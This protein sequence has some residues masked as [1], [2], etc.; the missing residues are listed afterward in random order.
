M[1][2]AKRILKLIEY[3][4]IIDEN[5]D[6]YNKQIIGAIAFENVSFYYNKSPVLKNLSFSIEPGE[7]VAIVGQTGSGKTTLTKLISRIN[8]VDN[9]K[10]LID[11][12]N[13]KVSVKS[14]TPRNTTRFIRI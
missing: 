6:G 11:G 13:I 7:T 14:C 8:D 9:G 12:V 10:V 1:A 4:S 3:D 5:R 2:A